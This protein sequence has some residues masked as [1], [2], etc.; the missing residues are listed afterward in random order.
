MSESLSNV[1]KNPDM[2]NVYLSIGSNI[3]R[4]LHISSGINS[5]KKRY[6]TVTCSPIYE[7]IAVGFE[8]D[9]FYNLVTH[10][11]TSDSIET[12][13]DYL[14]K[15]EDDNGRDRN[16]PKF[17]PR[18]LDL[19]LLLYDDQIIQ[20]EKLVLPR[21]EIYVNAFVL[22]PLADI[23]GNVIDPVKNQTYQQLWSSFDQDKQKLWPIALE[24]T[25]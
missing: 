22:R 10:F 19:D 25:H 5:L 18:T 4:S 8:G 20:S 1:A 13:S 12:L 11:S 23:A 17:G 14:S 16:G 2:A 3:Q 15:I 7:S 9:N 24:M 21:P 6:K